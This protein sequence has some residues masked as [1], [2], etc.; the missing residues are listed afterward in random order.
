MLLW[1]YAWRF[2]VVK[3]LL[4][5]V[6]GKAKEFGDLACGNF[7]LG[8]L[9]E[10]EC[11]Q[12]KPRALRPV[13][14]ELLGEVV[15][16]FNGNDHVGSFKRISELCNLLS[17]VGASTIGEVL[18]HAHENHMIQLDAQICRALNISIDV[19]TETADSSVVSDETGDQEEEEEPI[20]EIVLRCLECRSSELWGYREYIEDRSPYS[21]QQGIKGREFARVVVIIDDEE[22]KHFLFSYGKYFGV[23]ADRKNTEEGKET[24]SDRT[25]RLFYVC[26][27]RALKDLAVICY[28]PDPRSLRES[29]FG[30]GF[31]GNDA[32]FC[33]EDIGAN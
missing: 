1:S 18:R 31:F 17:R 21:T 24:I 2:V 9:L 12:Q 16:D 8:I 19:V 10:K 26:C 20:E 25:R 33:V 4:R 6:P 32:I 23:E 27:S 28:T 14:M 5:F 15:G 11:L 3:E 22:S 13:Q 7:T 30:K 29:V